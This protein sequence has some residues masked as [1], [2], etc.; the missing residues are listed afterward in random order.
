MRSWRTPLR[1]R[2][3]TCP[4]T[5]VALSDNL[6]ISTSEVW[7]VACRKQ[8][9]LRAG[10]RK[11]NAAAKEK[12]GSASFTFEQPTC[13]A[14]ASAQKKRR[15]SDRLPC[16]STRRKR[17]W[18]IT[19]PNNGPVSF[20]GR[21]LEDVRS[22]LLS[23]QIALREGRDRRKRR[24]ALPPRMARLSKSFNSELCKMRCLELMARSRRR[25]GKSVP[26]KTWLI[27][28][29]SRSMRSTGS[30]AASAVSQ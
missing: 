18:Q 20:G 17:S 22:H 8:R 28:A 19:L 15:R 11:L 23:F 1:H 13:T 21:V 14:G 9:R 29:T 7:V 12:S 30:L 4:R 25:Y 6:S 26:Y 16:Q 27:P 3:P 2:P 10:S 5:T 24:D